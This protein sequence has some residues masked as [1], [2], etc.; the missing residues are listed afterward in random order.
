MSTQAS[1][2]MCGHKIMAKQKTICSQMDMVMSILIKHEEQLTSHE[3]QLQHNVSDDVSTNVNI[4][5]A[6]ELD[7]VSFDDQAPPVNEHDQAPPVKEHD[8][9]PPVKEHDQAPPVKEHDQVSP[10]KEHDQAPPVNEHLIENVTPDDRLSVMSE[11]DNE[12]TQSNFDEPELMP[13]GFLIDQQETNIPVVEAWTIP[14]MTF[15][16]MV[17][18]RMLTTSVT[19][20]RER[21]LQSTIQWLQA[22]E[23]FRLKYKETLPSQELFFRPADWK[24]VTMTLLDA[25]M[26]VTE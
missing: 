13:G 2:H 6:K 15:R 5:D 25:I 21:T 24:E 10:V 19:A 16:I 22:R 11:T 17:S 23:T 3:K 1:D 26:P 7:N 18:E 9:V 8:Q 14:G 4:N 20:S 12:T